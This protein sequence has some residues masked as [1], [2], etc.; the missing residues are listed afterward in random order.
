MSMKDFV[1][2]SNNQS[3]SV[4]FGHNVN[5][6]HSHIDFAYIY[7]Q[8]YDMHTHLHVHPSFRNKY[9]HSRQS[10]KLKMSGVNTMQRSSLIQVRKDFVVQSPRTFLISMLSLV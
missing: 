4:L 8:I 2:A 9:F 6:S 1:Y 5:T 7:G 3:S 10:M